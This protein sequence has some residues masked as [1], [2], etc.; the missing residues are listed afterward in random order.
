[1]V[2][3][4]RLRSRPE[5]EPDLSI[6]LIAAHRGGVQLAEQRGMFDQCLLCELRV[7][8]LQSVYGIGRFSISQVFEHDQ[9][10]FPVARIKTRTE[11]WVMAKAVEKPDGGPIIEQF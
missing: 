10:V 11:R 9:S 5:S 2:K 3:L 4:Q 8:S 6:L 7:L 1:M